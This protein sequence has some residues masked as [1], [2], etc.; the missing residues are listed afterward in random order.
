MGHDSGAACLAGRR[1]T[2]VIL[3]VDGQMFE[4]GAGKLDALSSFACSQPGPPCEVLDLRR[5]VAAELPAR[6]IRKRLTA[7]DLA[8]PGGALF[9]YRICELL[10]ASETADDHL[11]KLG[12]N[13]QL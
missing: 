4:G 2:P 9:E 10:T 6:H 7:L 3:A 1:I 12:A 8:C 13:P 5:S 11:V